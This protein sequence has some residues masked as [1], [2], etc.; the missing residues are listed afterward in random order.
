MSEQPL[1][2][3]NTLTIAM[4]SDNKM[5]RVVDRLNFEINP[6]SCL[7]LVGESGSGK[8]ITALSIMQLLPPAA[9]VS[10]RSQ[11]SFEGHDLLDYSEQQMRQIRGGQIGMIFQDAMAAFNPVYTIGQQ[12]TETLRLH[13]RTNLKRAH[14]LALKLLDEVGIQDPKHTISAYPHQLSGGMRQRA[15]IAMALCGNPKMLIADEPTTALD[16][17]IQAQVIALLNTLK[18]KHKMTLLFI[19]HDL[20]IVSQLA[21]D[22]VVLKDGMSVEQAP[23]TTFFKSPQHDYSK[24]LLAAIPSQQM[25]D[26][27]TKPTQT[28][29]KVRA[30][31]VYFPIRK[32][33]LKRKVGDI[34]AVDD[35]SFDLASGQTLA[36]VG[37]SGSGK[38]TTG[39]AILSLLTKTSGHIYFEGK[40]LSH[41]SHKSLRLLRKDMQIIFQDPYSALNPRMLIA[42]SIAEGL[43]TQNIVH[44][45]QGA[46]AEVDKLLKQV[47][48]PLDSKWRYPHEFSGGQ[49]QRICIAR[50]LALKPKLL[51]LDEPT[52]ALDVSIQMQVLDLLNDLQKAMQLSYLLITHNLGVVGYMAQ[53]VAVMYRGKIVEQ[54]TCEDI[55]NNPQHPYTKSLL[56]SVPSIKLD[57]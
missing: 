45:H 31:K 28:M 54:G 55:L 3:L 33:L 8:S 7:G 12:L 20:A 48:L 57:N 19:S 30:L 15:M 24:A 21:D 26:V 35:I 27:T 32:G 13:Q 1:L 53:H 41:L 29:L 10:D 39:R 25:Q 4:A 50:A 40:D 49:R 42:D 36:L 37:E 11:I 2:Q 46:L 23:A 51:I 56:A 18:T 5:T 22:I 34:K 38:T 52:S 17:T 47:D 16:V 43:I 14:Q 6:G 44:S 9:R